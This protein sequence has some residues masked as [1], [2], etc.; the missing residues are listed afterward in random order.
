MKLLVLAQIPPPLHGQ[1][2]MVQTLVEGLPAHGVEVRHVPLS[3]SRDAA[4]IGRPSLMKVFT[5]LK[6][7]RRALVA[8]RQHRSEALYYV[9]APGKR[10]AV[11]RD[12]LVLGRLRRHCPRLVLHFHAAGLGEWLET[13]ARPWERTLGRRV[14]ADADLAIVLARALESDALKLTARHIAVVPN[15]IAS[16]VDRPQPRGAETGGARRRVLFVGALTA[17]KGVG[18]L[19][20][21]AARLNA[22]GETV[23]LIFAGTFMN[24][25]DRRHL[26]A[27]A[28]AYHTAT[29]W[30]GFVTGENKAALMR[31][32]DVLCLPTFYP[33]EA[34]P[35]VLLEALAHDLPIV[36]TRWRGIPETLPPGSALA[37]PRDA[38][39]LADALRTSLRTPPMPGIYRAHFLAHFTR[40]RH[41]TAMAAALRRLTPGRSATHAATAQL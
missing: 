27:A 2:L 41:L 40:E 32:A 37:E 17:E 22:G 12:I 16:P 7:T 23:E 8:L 6:V 1:S 5:A 19:L 33:H 21:A 26:K 18:V 4:D 13:T 24:E 10:V 28:R 3:F 11:W 25:A 9:P 31:S 14:L 15:G 36:A 30:A 20:E 38:R 29:T 34:Q 39:S 35:L